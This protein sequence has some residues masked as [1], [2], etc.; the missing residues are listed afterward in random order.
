MIPAGQFKQRRLVERLKKLGVAL[1]D[2][3]RQRAWW[4]ESL[5]EG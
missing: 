5:S 4:K 1:R 3:V 2:R